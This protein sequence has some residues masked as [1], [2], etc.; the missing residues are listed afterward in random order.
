MEPSTPSKSMKSAFLFLF[1]FFFKFSIKFYLLILGFILISIFYPVVKSVPL[2]VTES[3]NED[4]FVP[5]YALCIFKFSESIF[6]LTL[7][8][9][10]L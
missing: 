3:D 10:R 8:Q 5:K 7:T 2:L 1:L 4:A 9:C 6:K